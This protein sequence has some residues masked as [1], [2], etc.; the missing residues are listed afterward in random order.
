MVTLGGGKEETSKSAI[1]FIG[2]VFLADPTERQRQNPRSHC[3]NTP[4]STAVICLFELVLVRSVN[5]WLR[6]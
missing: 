4:K 2:F 1:L 3:R 5:G 6:I